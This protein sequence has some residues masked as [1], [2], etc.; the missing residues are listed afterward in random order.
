MPDYQKC[1]K[2]QRKLPEKDSYIGNFEGFS[3][4]KCK[5]EGIKVDLAVLKIL[6]LFSTSGLGDI[7][8]ISDVANY[9]EQLMNVTHAYLCD[10]LPKT[11]NSENL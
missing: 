10:I 8:K 7:L 1:R 4:G 11:P 9:N 3:C 5:G 6:R 2:C